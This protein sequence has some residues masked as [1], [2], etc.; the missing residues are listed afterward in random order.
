MLCEFVGHQRHEGCGK[1]TGRRDLRRLE[2]QFIVDEATYGP[3]LQEGEGRVETCWVGK[4]CYTLVLTP[5]VTAQRRQ[6]IEGSTF[7]G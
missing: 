1:G 6:E 3:E 7:G 5:E 4:K 2:S